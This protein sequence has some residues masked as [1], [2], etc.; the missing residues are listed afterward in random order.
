[1]RK[2]ILLILVLLSITGLCGEEKVFK[3]A[4]DPYAPFHWNDQETKKSIGIFVDMCDELIGRRMGYKVEYKEYPW[5]RAQV[6]VANG[7]E[8]AFIS[9][10][11][12]ERREYTVSGK[13]P[14][15]VMTRVIF[16]QPDNP[17]L[18]KLK[19]VKKVTDLKSMPKLHILDYIGDGWGEKYL[20]QQLGF[21][22]DKV[23]Q[24]DQV[25]NKLS[26]KRGDVFI[27]EPMIVNFKIRE[28]KLERNI[29][30]LTNSLDN[31]EFKLCISKK[32][33]FAKEVDAVDKHLTE[34]V[35]DGTM[36]KILKKWGTFR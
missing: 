25:V 2:K 29:I 10:P 5:K 21:E 11:T 20:E 27:E 16:T 19:A 7:V 33:P 13:V 6:N 26:V 30:Q 4:H 15:V 32:S 36:A 12:P 3:L 1:M 31:T 17:Y 9:L 35:K 14:F 23:A 8:D 34:M 18:G 24:V 22:L 28:L